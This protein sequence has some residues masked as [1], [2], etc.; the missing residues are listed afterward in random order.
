MA[1]S[2]LVIDDIAHKL[3]ACVCAELTLTAA[4]VDGQ[5]GCPCVACV[6]PGK[7]AWDNCT[8]D[9]SGAE[10]VGQLTVNLDKIFPT[11]AF[12]TE[13]K[14]V[15]GSRNCAPV[16]QAAEFVITLLR[17]APTYAPNGCPPSCEEQ[18]AAARILHVD[19]TAVINAVM[20][21]FPETTAARRGQQFTMGQL[22]TLGPEGQCVGIEQR[23]TVAL[24]SCGCASGAES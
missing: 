3:L 15:M 8:G 5:P 13:T 22:R 18:A 12:P 7:P 10:T 11:S 14:D 16:R 23:V 1:L 6:V 2:P 20:C 21:C 17:C 4:K 19:A 24:P 9:C